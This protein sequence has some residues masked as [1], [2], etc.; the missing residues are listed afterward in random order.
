M[1]YATQW[2]STI[3]REEPS[4]VA[5]KK[6]MI[7]PLSSNSSFEILILGRFKASKERGKMYEGE[8]KAKRS[9]PQCARQVWAGGKGRYFELDLRIRF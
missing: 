6:K 2:K 5:T 4:T 3:A 7:L 8:A 9:S 1:K